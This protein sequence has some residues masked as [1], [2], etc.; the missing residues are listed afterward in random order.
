MEED[1]EGGAEGEIVPDEERDQIKRDSSEK[2][3]EE[4][5]GTGGKVTKSQTVVNKIGGKML[6]E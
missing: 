4:G 5:G 3:E 2:T 6:N 1:E